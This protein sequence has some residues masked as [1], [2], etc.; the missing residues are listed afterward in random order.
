MITGTFS[1]TTRLVTKEKIWHLMADVNG[2]KHWDT[3]VEHAELLGKFESGSSFILKPAS[4]PRI[5]IKLVDVQP[6]GYFK[7]Q[8]TF[9]LAKMYGEHWYEDTPD[10]L[11]ITVRMTMTGL[12]GALWNKLVMKDIVSKL[13]EDVHLQIAIAQKR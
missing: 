3:G 12:L 8:T 4:G 11:K 7:D 9:P 2:W 10:G 13:E 1:A 6:Y 5:K